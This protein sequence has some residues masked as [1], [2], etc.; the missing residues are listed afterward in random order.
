MR[1]FC[2]YV[3]FLRLSWKLL[4]WEKYD[5]Y[6]HGKNTFILPL[7][8]YFKSKCKTSFHDNKQNIVVINS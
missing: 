2:E 7:F 3:H 4:M 8:L 6:A 1:I 5:D